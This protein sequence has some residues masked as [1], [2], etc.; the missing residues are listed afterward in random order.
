MKPYWNRSDVFPTWRDSYE[1]P[2][3]VQTTADNINLFDLDRIVAKRIRRG[4][5]EYLIGFRGYPDS[6][7]EWQKFSPRN[8]SDWLEDW[9]LLYAFDPSVGQSPPPSLLD[10]STTQLGHRRSARLLAT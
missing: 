1:R 5:T 6:H 9:E 4:F 7:N 3:P 10:S 2:S 8:P